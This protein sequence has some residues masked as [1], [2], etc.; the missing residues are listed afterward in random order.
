MKRTLE[1][2][3]ISVD[4]DVERRVIV[5]RRTS[6][7]PMSAEKL[8]RG[9]AGAMLQAD[10]FQGWGLLIDTR[11]APGQNDPDFERTLQRLRQEA[12]AIFPRVAMVVQTTVGELHA[13]RLQ[14]QR[15]GEWFDEGSEALVTRDFDE[16]MRH[17]AEPVTP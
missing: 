17:I 16:A 7:W 3:L 13:R 12:D 1:N 9:Y 8:A 6:S 15:R 11:D 14:L 5:V 10:Q 2:E 4:A